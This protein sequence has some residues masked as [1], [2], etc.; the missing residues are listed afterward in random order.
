MYLKNKCEQ[1]RNS[2]YDFVSPSC[3]D[4]ALALGACQ[5]VWGWRSGDLLKNTCTLLDGYL[6]GKGFGPGG[7]LTLQLGGVSDGSATEW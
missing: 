7:S 6:L 4:F 5:L 3:S 1:G 2:L